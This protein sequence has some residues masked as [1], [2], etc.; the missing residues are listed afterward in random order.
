MLERHSDEDNFQKF[1]SRKPGSPS[2]VELDSRRS[3]DKC[4][5]LGAHGLEASSSFWTPPAH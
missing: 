5:P 1:Y 3:L 2:P 4:R